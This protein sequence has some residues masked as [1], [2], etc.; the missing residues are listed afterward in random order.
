MKKFLSIPALLLMGLMSC[1]SGTGN[2]TATTDSTSTQ[3]DTS[4]SAMNM[5]ASE[6]LPEIPAGAKISFKTL[7]D[8]QT[9]SSPLKVEMSA[10]NISID[11]AEK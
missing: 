1:N 11:S 3:T 9:V 4:H 10:T 2:K 6:A 8:G 5:T 7:R